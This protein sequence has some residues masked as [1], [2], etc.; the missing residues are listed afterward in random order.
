MASFEITI[1][2]GAERATVYT[3]SI[4]EFVQ[5]MD[6][7]VTGVSR[8]CAGQPKIEGYRGPTLI[9]HTDTGEPILRYEAA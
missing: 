6:A 4:E 1:E 3:D 5:A 2:T 8:R 7:R 9:G